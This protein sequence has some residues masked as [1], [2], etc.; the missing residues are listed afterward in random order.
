M[1][2]SGC[3]G[4]LLQGASFTK[5]TEALSA[6]LL[7]MQVLRS[8]TLHWVVWGWPWALGTDV[9]WFLKLRV[10]VKL[11]QSGGLEGSI[12]PALERHRWKEF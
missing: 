10:H 2:M 1:W 3:L 6:L 4:G 12:Y 5:S 11:Q 9:P 7:G 8:A